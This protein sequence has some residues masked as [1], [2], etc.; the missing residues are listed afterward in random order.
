[1]SYNVE[2][3]ED[4]AKDVDP[5]LRYMALEDFQKSLNNPKLQVKGV[6]AFIPILYKLLNDPVADVQNQ[7]VKSFAPLVRHI[8]D[9]HTLGVVIHLFREAEAT[10]DESRFTTSVPNLALRSIFQN[11]HNR[12]GKNLSRATLETLL[13]QILNGT[14]LTLGRIEI[15]IDLMKYLG[16]L[17]LLEEI[18][19]I[20]KALIMC[21]FEE[22]GIVS[23][24]SI[25][26]VGALL[27]HVKT[28]CLGLLKQLLQFFN[29]IF[30]EICSLYENRDQSLTAKKA[31]F[32][33]FL[34]VLEQVRKMR[35]GVLTNEVVE[36]LISTITTNLELTN[37]KTD[38]GVEDLDIDILGEKNFLRDEI[39]NTLC[40]LVPC[41]TYESLIGEHLRSITT[42]LKVFISYN[43][44]ASEDHGE[45][46]DD[47]DMEFSDVEVIEE[48]EP[49][50][51]DGLAS[52]LRA[53]ALRVFGQLLT[54]KSS[55]LPQFFGSEIL[56]QLVD[57]ISDEVPA[58]SNQAIANTITLTRLVSELRH[59][60][61]KE[62]EKQTEDFYQYFTDTL[63]PRLE[64][65]IFQNLLSSNGVGRF[66][67]IEGLIETLICNMSHY[68]RKDFINMLVPKM[69]SLNISLKSQPEVIGIYEAILQKYDLD[70]IPSL[71]IVLGQLANAL[72]CLR[73][74]STSMHKFLQVSKVFYSKKP[75]SEMQYELANTL[76]FPAITDGI[77]SRQYS[78]DIR[79]QY[80]G[81]LSELLI[82]IP[83]SDENQNAA[84]QAF[85]ESLDFEATVSY[86][87]ECLN[88]ICEC[89]PQLFDSMH[90]SVL[91]IEKLSS[92]LGSGDSALY[93]SSLTLIQTILERT[94]YSGDLAVIQALGDKIIELLKSSTDPH[95]IN[96]A[97]FALGYIVELQ[98]GPTFNVETILNVV[99]HFISLDSDDLKNSSLEFLAKKIAA[100]HSTEGQSVCRLA[101]DKLDLSKFK[102][103][104]FISII[105][106]DCEL[107][108]EI[109][110]MEH[111]LT[112]KLQTLTREP[113]NEFIFSIH[114]LGCL[115]STHTETKFA[116]ENFLG[117]LNQ[118]TDDAVYMAAA[119]AL[120]SSAF[121]DLNT[122]LPLLLN[123]FQALSE[124]KDPKKTLLLVSVKQILKD[125]SLQQ[126]A[127]ALPLIWD[128]IIGT[129]SRESGDLAHEDIPAVKLA[130]E[131]LSTVANLD[132]TENYKE[133]ILQCFES[134][135]VR[136]GN[137][138]L[139][140]ALIVVTKLSLSDSESSYDE[141]IFEQI[142]SHLPKQNLDLKSAVVS[143]LLTAVY[144]KSATI[145][146]LANEVILP[147]IFD[148]LSAKEEFKKVIPMG[149]YKYVVDEGLEVRKLSYELISAMISV[150]DTIALDPEL[151]VDKIKIIEVLL[152]KGLSDNENDIINLAAGNLVQLVQ[153]DPLYLTQITN[154]HE[155][156]QSLVKVLNRTLRN[157]ATTQEAESHGDTLRAVIRL[158]KVI[159]NALVSDSA[160]TSEWS[161]YYNDLKI[162]HQLL[163]HGTG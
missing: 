101:F 117:I 39:L 46:F 61:G 22:S 142:V 97:L 38:E 109:K 83:I 11:S 81:N 53:L 143:T 150:N 16:S 90:L 34:T 32:T 149:P 110:A 122:K 128:A 102:S 58:V 89:N 15:L 107:K 129:I 92:Y 120:G 127:F 163:F 111:L 137:D 20:R 43:P 95:L 85:S 151:Q 27:S 49:E 76:F 72:N 124:S 1:M 147:L 71:D 2:N 125:Y 100:K 162:R 118:S 48:E 86:T 98:D 108:D 78:S 19:A 55:V 67:H 157:K 47:D 91:I 65:S 79:Q 121:S 25:V 9:E 62:Q 8:D 5:D 54:Y 30:A 26:A 36:L 31:M 104:K 29:S 94:Q 77:N 12:F 115:A 10:Q 114:F 116:F 50:N 88:Y 7:A 64:V 80:L 140:F 69:L 6:S 136:T 119:R 24:R 158:S 145:F 14:T 57:S 13:P 105:V 41:I 60:D 112:S 153:K 138:F 141:K 161:S 126:G 99:A 42:I 3:L 87:I 63:V 146:K 160:L 23:K 28:A 103:A 70:Q 56:D 159:N 33:L 156:I 123:H 73:A 135:T 155:L 84:I 68:L 113:L 131:I 139:L 82:Q 134:Q 66:A 18:F 59:E 75:M 21:A 130:G 52:Q 4:P 132:N 152:S 44:L 35:G 148:E 93:G 74:Y 144:N 96:E 154:L 37:I 133:K 51:D 45:F 17:L 40:V 106:K